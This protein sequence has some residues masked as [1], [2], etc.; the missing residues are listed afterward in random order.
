MDDARWLRIQLWKPVRLVFQ[1]AA[2]LFEEADR[3][4]TAAEA[5]LTGPP[6]VPARGKLAPPP[7]G[8]PAAYLRRRGAL[9][10]LIEAQ[11]DPVFTDHLGPWQT[12]MCTVAI[13]SFIDER[14]RVALGA[15]ADAWH[16]PLLQTEL[17]GIDD[18]GDRTFAQIHE[19]LARADV[20]DL[21]FEV[22]L[23]CLRAG[24]VGRHAGRRHELDRIAGWIVD[25]LRRHPPRRAAAVPDAPPPTRRRI[26]FVGFPLRYYLGVAVVVAGVF[27]G[28]RMVSGREVARSN[29]AEYC[30]Y[31]DEGTP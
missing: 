20:H 5:E 26:G 12:H 22:H 21:V 24:L 28:L 3:L 31:R 10:E 8:A 25:R 17:L 16:L 14:E 19:L 13:V 27:V 6:P 2:E 23:L 4:R 29:L 1:A 18:G 7:P 9:R 15:Q 11:L 30:H